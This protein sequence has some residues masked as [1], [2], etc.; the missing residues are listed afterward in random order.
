MNPHRTVSALVLA[1]ALLAPQAQ[2]GDTPAGG[3]GWW[4]W[5]ETTVLEMIWGGQGEDSEANRWEKEGPTADPL[6]KV[7]PTSDPLGLPTPPPPAN[8]GGPGA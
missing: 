3:R 6:G 7:G 8:P 1:T 4:A 2:A 5:L